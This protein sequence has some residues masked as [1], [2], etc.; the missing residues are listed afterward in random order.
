MDCQFV[1][2]DFCVDGL[3]QIF[4]G[5]TTGLTWNGFACPTFESETADSIIAALV[6]SGTPTK[7]SR[8]TECIT[9]LEEE[10]PDDAIEVSCDLIDTPDGVKKVFALG[11]FAWCWHQVDGRQC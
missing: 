2:A 8:S 11:A 4:S 6:K 7:F 5:W 1:R 9:I 3:G 10:Y